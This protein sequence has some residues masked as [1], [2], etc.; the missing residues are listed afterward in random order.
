MLANTFG[1]GLGGGVGGIGCGGVFW[2]CW[3]MCIAP[4]RLIFLVVVVYKKPLGG[5]TLPLGGLEYLRNL[6]GTVHMFVLC[7]LLAEHNIIV[8]KN[9]K[10]EAVHLLI[11]CVEFVA[12]HDSTSD[13]AKEEV[14]NALIETMADYVDKNKKA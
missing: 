12:I 6:C 8:N 10:V 2:V 13:Q 1:S 5:C 3:F 9:R 14:V 4:F 7:S 11:A